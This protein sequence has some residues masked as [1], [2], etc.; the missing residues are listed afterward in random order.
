MY[1][2]FKMSSWNLSA[3]QKDKNSSAKSIDK[4]E[5]HTKESENNDESSPCSYSK[6]EML[7]SNWKSEDQKAEL[8]NNKSGEWIKTKIDEQAT[9]ENSEIAESKSMNG[10][11]RKLSSPA[12]AS[13]ST[14]MMGKCASTPMQGYVGHHGYK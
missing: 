8:G 12:S 4:V 13:K 11:Q 9:K 10:Q 3:S 7:D 2:E 1:I 5:E 14:K 6:H